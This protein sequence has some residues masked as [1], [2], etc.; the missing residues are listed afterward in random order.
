M[1]SEIITASGLITAEVLKNIG[2][3][4]GQYIFGRVGDNYFD[5]FSAKRKLKK[6]L[7]EDEKNIEQQ[8]QGK[9]EKTDIEKIKKFFFE[10][11]FQNAVFLYPV[12]V[13]PK[14]RLDLLEKQFYAYVSET[15]F[16]NALEISVSD[17]AK[18]IN[19]HNELVS[20]YLLS[21][22]ERIMLKTIQRDQSDLLGYTGKTLDSNSELQVED[23]T[24]DYTHRQIEGILHAMRMDMQHYKFLMLLYSVGILIIIAIA[25]IILPQMLK[26][27][28]DFNSISSSLIVVLVLFPLATSLLLYLFVLSLRNVK[29]REEKI[30]KYMELLW[31][32]H[33]DRYTDFFGKDIEEWYTGIKREERKPSL[34]DYWPTILTAVV[35]LVAVAIFNFYLLYS[36]F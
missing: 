30:L 25:I 15:N 14:E 16:Q 32:L 6:V 36:H 8:F 29:I 34:S 23:L 11:A 27:A 5:N 9:L 20:K 12:S 7:K 31:K 18:C 13:F 22:S 17:L 26:A 21:E 28:N 10:D 24:L 3:T 2:S 19:K 33:F 4:V 35:A 1:V